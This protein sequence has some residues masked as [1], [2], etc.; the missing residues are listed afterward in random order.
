[1]GSQILEVVI[2]DVRTCGEL[3]AVQATPSQIGPNKLV[4]Q[5]GLGVPVPVSAPETT[6]AIFGSQ[7][8]HRGIIL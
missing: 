5:F 1:M 8:M 3:R 6:M 4:A 7:H 2:L